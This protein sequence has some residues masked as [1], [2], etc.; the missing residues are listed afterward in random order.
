M[1]VDAL[2]HGCVYWAAEPPL[3]S[4]RELMVAMAGDVPA[5]HPATQ[6]LRAGFLLATIE[7]WMNASAVVTEQGDEGGDLLWRL[8]IFDVNDLV[9]D[10]L[11]DVINHAAAQA[12]VGPAVDAVARA[13]WEYR[14]AVR[15][16]RVSSLDAGLYRRALDELTAARVRYTALRRRT[17]RKA[18]EPPGHSEPA[19]D[20][21]GEKDCR[22]YSFAP[23]RRS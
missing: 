1:N 11:I 4:S 10:R 23:E 3:P 21:I 13:W 15:Y 14:R 2:D 17:H 5:A 19:V 22:G 7:D 6:I 12:D 16:R 8:G 9:R 20:E 18:S